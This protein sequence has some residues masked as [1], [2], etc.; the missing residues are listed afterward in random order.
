MQAQDWIDNSRDADGAGIVRQPAAQQ[1]AEPREFITA[2]DSASQF[3]V[4]NQL[5][6][7][8]GVYDPTIRADS[9]IRA[10]LRYIEDS[11]GYVACAKRP[12][13]TFQC[14]ADGNDMALLALRDGIAHLAPNAPT[15][16]R[17]RGG[18]AASVRR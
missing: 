13:N 6:T 16:Y 4:E 7:L 15:E 2:V 8:Y 9:H 5:V 3:V 17:E 11:H 12:G 18:Q 10:I 14:F 1:L